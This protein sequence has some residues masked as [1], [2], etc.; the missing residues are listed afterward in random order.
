LDVVRQRGFESSALLAMFNSG[1]TSPPTIWREIRELLG[2]RELL[3]A[4]GMTE[5]TASTTCT[6]PEDPDEHLLTSNGRLKAAGVAGDPELHGL[7]ALYKAIDPETG[8][9]LPPGTAGELVV[10]GP[11][12]TKGY[13]SKPE[14][15]AAAFHADGW[16]RTGDIGTVSPDGFVTLSGRIKESYRCGGEMVMPQEIEELLNEHPLVERA[17]A[18]GVPDPKMG[19]VGCACVIPGGEHPDKQQLI[20]LC[21][22]RLA[23]FKVPRHL[24][25]ITHED[26]PI[27]AT[28]RPQRVHLA[29]LARQRLGI[30]P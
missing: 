13:Y 8:A 16:L 7:L 6:L 20:D 26:L 17:Y 15:T 25:F 9:D 18:V 27:T 10:R 28:G 19:E 4:Y 22:T 5:T 1:G 14:E 3:T 30:A 21:A 12:V 2:A 11:I 29:E 24:I 23:R